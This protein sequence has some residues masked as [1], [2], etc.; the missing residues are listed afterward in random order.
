MGI[1]AKLIADHEKLAADQ[2]F[3]RKGFIVGS[4]IVENV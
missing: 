3:F 1:H 4:K 2:S